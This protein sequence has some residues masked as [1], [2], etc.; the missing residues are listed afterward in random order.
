ME[1]PI[2]DRKIKVQLSR[3]IILDTIV[4]DPMPI[5]SLPDPKPEDPFS[6]ASVG[7][8]SCE[9]IST[10]SKRKLDIEPSL[11]VTVGKNLKH[12]LLENRVTSKVEEA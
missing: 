6:G 10:L 4:E 11:C 8:T 12:S 3:D 9:D 5:P 1:E 7:M 2:I